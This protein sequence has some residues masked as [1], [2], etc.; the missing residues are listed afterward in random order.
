MK[1]ARKY[2]KRI[3]LR[4][5]TYA[6]DGFA[7]SVVSGDELIADRWANVKRVREPNAA[8]LR[9]ENGI[10]VSDTI[11]R[12]TLRYISGLELDNLFIEYQGGIYSPVTIQQSTEYETETVILATLAKTP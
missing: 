9:Q 10:K 3:S 2:D 8:E 6:S 12:F 1:Q 4:R 7:G 5:T 11:L